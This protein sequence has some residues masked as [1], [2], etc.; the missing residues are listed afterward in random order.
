MTWKGKD[1]YTTEGIEQFDTDMRILLDYLFQMAFGKT[2][3]S[4]VREYASDLSS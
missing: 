3:T 2:L 1:I 4:V